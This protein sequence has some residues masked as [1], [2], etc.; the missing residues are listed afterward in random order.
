MDLEFKDIHTENQLN[1]VLIGNVNT[2]KSTLF[3]RICR[4]SIK[5]GNYSGTSVSISMGSLHTHQ[6]EHALIDTP[7]SNTI[8]G[9]NE[10]EIISKKILLDYPELGLLFVADAKNLKRSL[11]LYLHYT[12]FEFPMLLNINM[13]DE[14][15]IKNIEINTDKLAHI[16]GVEVNTSVAIEGNG[17]DNLKKKL[18][19][20][21]VSPY[22]IEYPQFLDGYFMLAKQITGNNKISRGV[23]LS[24]LMDD[25]LTIEYIKTQFSDTLYSEIEKLVDQTKT[26]TSKQIETL[27]LDIYLEEA[28]KI[29][30]QV[31]WQGETKQIPFADKLGIWSRNLSTGIPIATLIIIVMY[32]FV[33]KFGAEFLVDLLEGQLFGETITPWV[34][35]SIN[36]FGLELLTRA[37]TGEFGIVSV[38]LALSLGLVMPVLLTFYFFFG[39][40]ENSGYLPRLAILLNNVFKKMGMS[41]KGVLPMIMGF[42]CITMAILTTRVLDTAKEKNIATFLLIL[43][44]PCAPLFSVMLVILADMP[45][46]AAFFIFGFIALQILTIGYFTNKI[47]KGKQPEFVMEIPPLRIPKLKSISI[48]AFRRTNMFLKEAIPVFLLA[49]IIVFVLDEIGGIALIENLSKP[50]LSG[51]VGLP[52][53]SVNVF[54]VSVIRR[55]AGVALLTEFIAKGIFNHIQIVV[56]LLIIT[57]LMPCINAIIVIIKER[58][59]KICVGICSFVLVYAI[60]IGALV[61]YCLTFLQNADVI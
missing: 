33:G 47:F 42:S 30:Q 57:F 32:Y 53:E 50:V 27:L 4:Q 51:F 35:N 9:E 26:K 14:A 17:I 21:T 52:K 39:L 1:Y 60:L 61:N 54:I 19:H 38:G 8:H 18:P 36:R 37:I 22:E 25:P 7:G 29:Y 31:A 24:L 6:G 55:E 44:I 2:G 15:I 20:A 48:N 59:V 11:A 3:N 34:E 56:N 58:G 49:S 10:D 40:L 45:V 16:L 28:E 23:L 41:G 5:E 12:E 43:G 46:W 13:M